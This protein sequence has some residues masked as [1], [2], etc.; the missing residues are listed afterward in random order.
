M[1]RWVAPTGE[2]VLFTGDPVN[3]QVQLELAAPDHFRRPNALNFGARP[4][5]VGRH[6]EPAALKATLSRLLE[7]DF[8]VVCGS[9][10]MPFRENA[11]AAL[12][13]LLA[14]I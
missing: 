4:G 8:D 14:K 7:W 2:G 13:E 10:G 1:L 9:H 5:Y 12:G 11:K 6:R 3:G